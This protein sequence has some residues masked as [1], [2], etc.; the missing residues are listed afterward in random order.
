MRDVVGQTN[1]GAPMDEPLVLPCENRSS[2]T[3][4]RLAIEAEAVNGLPV[5]RRR[6][7]PR[8]RNDSEMV[9]EWLRTGRWPDRIIGEYELDPDLCE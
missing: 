6:P 4:Q 1:F 3:Q 7:Q 9:K 5:F 2:A 8:T